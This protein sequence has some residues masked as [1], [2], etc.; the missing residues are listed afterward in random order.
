MIILC[1]DILQARKYTISK[2]IG[3]SSVAKRLGLVTIPLGALMTRMLLKFV[4]LDFWHI[5]LLLMFTL[6]IV[7]VSLPLRTTEVAPLTFVPRPTLPCPAIPLEE[8]QKVCR[9]FDHLSF[10]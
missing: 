1:D 5:L 2:S 6:L 8:S 3:G 4:R 9:F 7:K 10:A